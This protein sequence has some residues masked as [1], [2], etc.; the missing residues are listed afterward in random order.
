MI[1]ASYALNMGWKQKEDLPRLPHADKPRLFVMPERQLSRR[2]FLNTLLGGAAA[3]MAGAHTARAED[4]LSSSA[5]GGSALI[6]GG[7]SSSECGRWASLLAPALEEE[8]HL[9]P[10]CNLPL[11][12][13]GMA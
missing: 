4:S 13:G 11:Q 9:S 2:V 5:D 7:T 10:L 12:P 1:L 3:V 6:I 8:L